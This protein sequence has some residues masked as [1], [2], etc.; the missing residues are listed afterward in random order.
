MKSFHAGSMGISRV[1]WR[2]ACGELWWKLFEGI[3]RIVLMLNIKFVEKGLFFV[4]IRSKLINSD[5]D[6]SKTSII[7]IYM[8][9]P[10]KSLYKSKFSHIPSYFGRFANSIFFPPNIWLKQWGKRL[11]WVKKIVEF[12]KYLSQKTFEVVSCARGCGFKSRQ[13]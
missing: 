12:E 1:D 8:Q 13:Q 3:L 11:V 10:S 7:W 5:F 6:N 2:L 9:V 4:T